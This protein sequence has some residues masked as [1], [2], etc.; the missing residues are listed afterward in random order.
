MPAS[1]AEATASELRGG[2]RHDPPHRNWSCQEALSRARGH[3]SGLVNKERDRGRSTGLC[4][5]P[6]QSGCNVRHDCCAA[7]KRS[8]TSA[9]FLI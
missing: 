9:F 6:P 1:A 5:H 2:G 8:D 3:L 7:R 4:Q